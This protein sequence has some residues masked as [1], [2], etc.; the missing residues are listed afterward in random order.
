MKKLV[1]FLAAAVAAILIVIPVGAAKPVPS[2]TIAIAA[3]SDLNLGGVVTFD[4]TVSDL[5]GNANPR[6]Q[7]MCSQPDDVPFDYA[8]PDGSIHTHIDPLVYGEAGPAEQGFLLGG[9]MSVWLLHGG[10]AECVATLY[11]WTFHPVQEFH[12]LASVSF[13]AGG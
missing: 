5:P 2:G 6:I 9:G 13:G 10:P 8:F 4:V 3:G 11:F 7:V 12:E 1:L